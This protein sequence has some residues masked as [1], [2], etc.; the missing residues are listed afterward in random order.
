MKLIVG[1]GNP[2][3]E[4]EKTRHNI[5]F[6]IVDEIVKLYGVKKY[7]QKFNSFFV[8]LNID[9]EQVIFLKPLTY[10]NNS[11]EAVKD[12]MDYFKIS[13]NN[14]LIVYDDLD[15]EVGKIRFKAKS[16]NGGHNGI[17]SIEQKINTSDFKRLKFG[18][19]RSK[20]IPVVKYVLGSF[21]KK[22]F[23][24]VKE[25]IN[26]ARNACV[27]FITYDFIRLASKYN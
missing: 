20:S 24:Y 22:D 8:K 19:G 10:M 6:I 27:D 3:I 1:L 4:Y 13:Y 14:I 11:G 2:G 15:L 23:D 9:N 26:V 18:I 25:R 21:D 16:S 12:C 17:K 5:G 7:S